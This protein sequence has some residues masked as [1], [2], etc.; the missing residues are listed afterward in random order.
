MK[1]REFITF[2]GGAAATWPLTARA[3][4]P[5]RVI[6]VLGSAASGSFH[7]AEAAFI[8]GLKDAGF[9]EGKNISIEWHW[10]EGKYNRLSLLAGELV[11]RNVS[12]IPAFDLPSALAA[13]AATK[14]IPIVFATGADPVKLGLVDSFNQP[15]GNLTGVFTLVSVLAPKQLELL[16]EILPSAGTIVLLVNASNPNAQADAPEEQAAAHVLGQRLE[17]LTASTDSDLEAA[18][19]TMVERRASALIVK[20]DP[21]FI[22]RRER[23]VALA[24]RHAMPAIYSL[25]VFAE[26]GGL[27]SYAT[28]FVDMYQQAG[29]YAGKIVKGA[30]PADLP[31]QQGVK[32]ELVINLKTAKALG[33]EVPFHLLQLADEVIE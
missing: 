11:A 9:I 32:F 17:V 19:T 14:T 7:G 1:R 31:V 5:R 2:L 22:D 33:L 15:R 12:V 3:Q 21:F 28:N 20:A 13:K 25:R 30:K 26:V 8:Q 29:T 27:V 23:L 16:H 4:E 6:G 10:A 18:F 24:A